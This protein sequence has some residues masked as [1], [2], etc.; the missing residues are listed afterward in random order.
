[1]KKIISVI[2][3]LTAVVFASYFNSLNSPFIWDDE[4]LVI[5]NPLIRTAIPSPKI[6]TSDLYNGISAGSNFYRPAQTFSYWFNFRLGGLEP[7]GYHLTNILLQAMVSI[8]VFI[9]LYILV[10]DWM[11]AFAASLFFAANPLSAEAVTYV[12]GR[13]EML[14]GL[15]LISSLILF[16]KSLETRNKW[17][18]AL[19]LALFILGLLSKELALVFPFVV[20]AY[21][22]YFRREEARSRAF[23]VKSVFPF[24]LILGVYLI[25]RLTILSFST[26]RP[27]A[28]TAVPFYLRISVL[29]KVFLTYFK[30]LVMPVGL[31]MSRTLL[32]PVS[33]AGF[34]IAWFALGALAVLCFNIFRNKNGKDPAFYVFLVSDISPA[35][36]RPPCYQ[37][38]C[39]GAFYISV[40]REFLPGA[41]LF[42][43]KISK[44]GSVYCYGRCDNR[45]L[46]A[47]YHQP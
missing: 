31:H 33:P 5:K 8:L 3:I 20:L 16:I 28:L 19:S 6:L 7:F 9:L 22:Y 10:K 27:P 46:L 24:F 35:A 32:R 39:L 18:F 47:P 13:A 45:V 2:S 44:A 1:M 17:Q 12:S 14:L 30:L 40:Q 21:I 37:R 11:L 26:L 29:P 4:A 15:F 42:I 25:L 34:F 41:G 38:L 23:V 36:V 43:K